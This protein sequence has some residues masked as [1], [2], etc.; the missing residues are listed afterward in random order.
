MNIANLLAPERTRCGATATSKKRCLELLSELLTGDDADPSTRAVFESL[1]SRER[2]GSTGL[3]KG[4]ALPHAR[5]PGIDQATAAL[6]RLDKPVDFDAIDRQPVDL[7]FALLVPE[8]STDEHLRILAR[9]AEMFSDPDLCERLRTCG[10]ET[11]LYET[12]LAW[13][14]SRS[15]S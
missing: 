2:L 10:S 4:V 1:I 9:L 13:Q 15:G 8:H 5:A 12:V 3:G 11:E 6:L 14:D 7:L